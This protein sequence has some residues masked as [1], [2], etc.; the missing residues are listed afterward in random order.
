MQVEQK[1]QLHQVTPLSKYL[2][3]ALFIILPFVGGYVGYI[4]APEKVV[5]VEKVVI[6]E[7]VVVKEIEVTP[8][9]SEGSYSVETKTYRDDDLGITFEY[10]AVWGEITIDNEV[11][12]CSAG[13]TAD[14]CNF[15]TL[16][17]KDVY[18]AAIFLSAET[19]G[20][21]GQSNWAW[22]FLGRCS[23]RDFT[24]LSL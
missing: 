2:A 23:G 20:H 1:S 14:D 9:K 7:V 4:F 16:L 17:L 12:N 24:K 13:Y 15:R 8:Q 22:R 5:E 19:K 3:M 21:N 10:P 18:S 11:G 6:Q